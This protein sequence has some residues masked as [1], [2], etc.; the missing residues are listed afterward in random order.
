MAMTVCAFVVASPIKF[1][2]LLSMGRA[3]PKLIEKR[4][5][6]LPFVI[7]DTP[8]VYARLSISRAQL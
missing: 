7:A 6:V 3:V 2:R 8:A 5:A 1:F 4:R